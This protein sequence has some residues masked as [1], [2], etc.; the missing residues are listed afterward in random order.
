[1][2]AKQNGKKTQGQVQSG[3]EEA[4]MGLTPAQGLGHD[5]GNVGITSHKRQDV[6]SVC[7]LIAVIAGIVMYLVASRGAYVD[8]HG[9]LHES[10]WLIVGA[11]TLIVIGIVLG[12]AA[13]VAWRKA[14]HDG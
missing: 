10:F 11:K 7:C 1:M 14:R 13:I 9:L 12:I 6:L 2:D 5:R 8:A 4:G 3:S